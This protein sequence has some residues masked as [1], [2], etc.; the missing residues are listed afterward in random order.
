MTEHSPV[1]AF[2]RILHHRRD[3]LPEPGGGAIVL[4]HGKR[5]GTGGGSDT[6]PPL[7]LPDLRAGH[8][9]TEGASHKRS[10]DKAGF[11]TGIF[12]MLLHLESGP[13][14]RA[15]VER[16]HRRREVL[17]HVEDIGHARI[18]RWIWLV[19]LHATAHCLFFVGGQ[20]L[21]I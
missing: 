4:Q 5:Q 14:L 8:H 21:L 2:H 7:L 13:R 17:R 20:R 16:G 12:R 1:R 18:D 3:R 19:R 10:G 9:D 11:H 15:R 6:H